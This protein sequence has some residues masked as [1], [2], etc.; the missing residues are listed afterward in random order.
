MGSCIH[1]NDCTVC[2][3]STMFCDIPVVLLLVWCSRQY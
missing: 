2:T 3:V 1:I